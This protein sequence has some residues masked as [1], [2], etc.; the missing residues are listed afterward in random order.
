MLSL[1]NLPFGPIRAPRHTTVDE[2]E[3]SRRHIAFGVV[4][5]EAFYAEL[6]EGERRERIEFLVEA[7]DLALR[8]FLL[9]EVWERVEA[10]LARVLR[11]RQQPT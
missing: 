3:D 8:R 11:Q 6:T 2:L 5:L 1:K 4:Q 9:E 7:S 10:F